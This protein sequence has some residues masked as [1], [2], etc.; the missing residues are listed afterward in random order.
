MSFFYLLLYLVEN[1]KP[2]C[3]L[4]TDNSQLTIVYRIPNTDFD[5]RSTF[6]EGGTEYRILIIVHQIPG[7][8]HPYI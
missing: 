2:N 3:R 5:R 8:N 7:N 1:I 4:T 6:R